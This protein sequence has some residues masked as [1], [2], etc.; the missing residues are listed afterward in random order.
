MTRKDI[1]AILFEA[2]KMESD[3]YVDTRPPYLK[4]IVGKPYPANYTPPI[5]LKYDG[6]TGNTREHIRWYVDALEA[7]SHDHELRF[8][9]FFKFLEG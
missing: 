5:F 8:R 4:E 7:H 2:K 9:E 6:I 3:V 1:H